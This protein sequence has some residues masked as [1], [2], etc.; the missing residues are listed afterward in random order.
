HFRVDAADHASITELAKADLLRKEY[1]KVV[2]GYRWKPFEPVKR[3]PIPT[4]KNTAWVRNAID[5]FLAA[6]H[7]KLG[8]QPRPEASRSVLIRRVYLDLIG[9]PPTP[10][11]IQAFVS[12]TSL[13]AY[14]RLVDRL[15]QS[16]HYGERWGRHWMDIW[17]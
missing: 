10:E 3:P 11:E 12:D 9:L 7:E 15:L 13:D 4:V 8:L 6:E 17:R 1:R 5:A 16:P 14:A 2:A